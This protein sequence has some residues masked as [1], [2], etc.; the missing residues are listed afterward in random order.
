MIKQAKV[1]QVLIE[2]QNGGIFG[3]E[4]YL[5]KEDMNTYKDTWCDNI[6]TLIKSKQYISV[7]AEIELI[8]QKF[9]L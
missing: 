9:K 1:K 6:K 7:S 2:Y 5:N 3:V 4:L 8:I